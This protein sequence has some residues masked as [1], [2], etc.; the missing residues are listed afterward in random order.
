MMTE[1]H[2]CG[3]RFKERAAHVSVSDLCAHAICE[4]QPQV[5][6][7]D[8]TAL[9]AQSL[10]TLHASVTVLVFTESRGFIRTE[11]A[12]T[13]PPHVPFLIALQTTLRV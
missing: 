10:A 4:Q 6:E 3:M 1:I 11:P 8:Q 9:N 5:V 12:D 7:R 13:S 2:D